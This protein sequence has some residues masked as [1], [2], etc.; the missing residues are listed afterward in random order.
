MY[1][2]KGPRQLKQLGGRKNKFGR[3]SLPNFKNYYKATTIK[4]I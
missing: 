4:T 1:K 3:L 2:Y